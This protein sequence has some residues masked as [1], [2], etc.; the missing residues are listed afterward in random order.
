[1][2]STFR[3]DVAPLTNMKT[4]QKISR[5]A[6]L[7]W[8]YRRRKEIV[9]GLPIRLWIESTSRCNLR[10]VMCPNKD[11][12]AS[13]KGPMNYALFCKIVDEAR[14][15][16]QDIYLHHRG[17]PL[18]NPAI[19]DM[20]S[21]A[22]QAGLRTRFHTNG[23]LLTADK[24]RKL[25]D[26]GPDL[27]SFSV[28]GFDKET[29]EAIR[30]GAQ[31]EKTVTNILRL[32][33]LKRDLNLTKPYVV[34]EKIRFRSPERPEDPAAVK[35]LR[36]RLL[37]AGINEVIE[38]DEYV[39]TQGSAPVIA[40][41]RTCKACTFPWYAMVICADGSVTPCPQDFNAGMVMGNVHT[42]SLREI[43]NGP[44]Y[45]ALRKA[46]A[47]GI[48]SYELCRRCDRLTRK[49]VGGI[50]FQYMATFL[51]DQLIGY[52]RFRKWMGTSERN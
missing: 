14:H 49:T 20:I 2:T 36:E 18:L 48:Q 23:A 27:V 43:W 26:A 17:E 41:A 13:E 15:F 10:C 29:Y 24:T 52:N 3:K 25:L 1:M 47:S 16:A 42:A 40:E 30:V 34:V 37:Q 33:E 11:M 44:A 9:G 22:A 35:S 32:L 50:P 4:S 19:F 39:W 12:P 28:D 46:F 5:L 51:I 8:E 31:F 45:Q 7:V 38:K 6:Q 21:Y